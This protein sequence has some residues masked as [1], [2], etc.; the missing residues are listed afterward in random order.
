MGSLQKLR[1]MKQAQ[2]AGFIIEARRSLSQGSVFWASWPGLLSE[3]VFGLKCPP[4]R[5][6]Y[7]MDLASQF[8]PNEVSFYEMRKIANSK[9]IERVGISPRSCSIKSPV[10]PVKTGRNEGDGWYG[11]GVAHS[12]LNRHEEAIESFERARA[13]APN[14]AEHRIPFGGGIDSLES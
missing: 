8:I 4:E 3:M 5:R 11:K 6:E 12:R 2:F 14:D 13:L 1:K 9:S 7:Y 10:S